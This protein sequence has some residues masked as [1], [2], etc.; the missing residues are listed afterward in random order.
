MDSDWAVLSKTMR[1]IEG[2]N[3]PSMREQNLIQVQL[4]Y[5]LQ[6]VTTMKEK[7]DAYGRLRRMSC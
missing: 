6:F 1:T 2:K 3:I 4:I 7:Q 5:S